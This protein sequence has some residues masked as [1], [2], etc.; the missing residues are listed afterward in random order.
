[1]K[2][3]PFSSRHPDAPIRAVDNR[4]HAITKQEVLVDQYPLLFRALRHKDLYPCNLAFIGFQCPGGW[5]N[6]IED[7][8]SS[9][10]E[11]LWQLWGQPEGRLE[12]ILAMD[13]LLLKHPGAPSSAKPVVPFCTDVRDS[14]CSLIISMGSGYLQD[15][16][17]EDCIE[18]LTYMAREYST[19]RC[20]VCGCKGTSKTLNYAYCERCFN[21]NGVVKKGGRTVSPADESPRRLK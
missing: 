20:P 8:A 16:P 21:P 13:R 5:M 3:I 6:I 19:N 11:V 18:G 14:N 7:T 2:E 4:Y 10:E 9:L 17:V 15:Q 12:D 1:M